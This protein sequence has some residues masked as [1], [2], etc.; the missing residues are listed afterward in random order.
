MTKMNKNAWK[1]IQNTFY[2]YICLIS[3]TKK[4]PRKQQPLLTVDCKDRGHIFLIQF[5]SICIT[6]FARLT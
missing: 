5:L 6:P 2:M 4:Q 1:L 3:V